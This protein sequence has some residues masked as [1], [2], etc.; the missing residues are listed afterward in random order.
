MKK[1]AN[2]KLVLYALALINFTH[3]V[4]SMLIMP[5]GDIFI[6]EFGISPAEYGILVSGY[7]FSAFLSSLIGVFFIDR[8]DRRR[9]LLL[10]YVGFSLGTLACV[11]ANSYESLLLLRMATGF[12]GGMIGTIVLSVVSDL[13]LFKKRGAAMGVLFA[14]FSAAS[15]LGVPIGIYLAAKGTWQLPFMIIGATALGISLLIYFLFPSMTG[16]L[17][18]QQKEFDY[19]RTIHNITSDKNQLRALAAGFVLILAHFL[20]IPFISPYLIQ[21]VGLTQMEISYQFFFGGLATIISSPV[22]GRLTDTYG[23]MK[24]FIAVMLISWVPTM[25]IT[26]L[27]VV[28]VALAITYTTMFFI[29]ASGRMIPSNTIITAAAGVENRGSFMSIKSAL[30]QLAIGL[31]A[32]IAGGIIHTDANGDFLYYEYVGLLSIV[33]GIAAIWL[34]SRIRVAKGN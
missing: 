20:I 2:R 7:A 24:V 8:F 17:D 30:Q 13:Y 27:S 5:L 18:A 28:P 15:A 14:A 31:S 10:I 11:F 6:S 12:F 9:F 29:F 25:L 26:T 1:L 22:I 21:N 23:V 32:L 4:D 19:K 33:A 34:V 16:H 3:I